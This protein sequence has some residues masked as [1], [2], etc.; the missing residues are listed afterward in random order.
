MAKAVNT[1]R[2]FTRA[3]SL[4]EDSPLPAALLPVLKVMLKQQHGSDFGTKPVPRGAEPTSQ[5]CFT[6]PS[7]PL[8]Q[9]VG[10]EGGSGMK[11]SAGPGALL[12]ARR[13]HPAPEAPG[14]AGG[15]CAPGRDPQGTGS[16]PQA[17][18]LNETRDK[19]RDRQ[20]HQLLS[21]GY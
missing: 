12:A 13:G 6:Q 17:R 1:W 20:I 19:H 3:Q 9:R 11:G 21:K 5:A 10:A 18:V 16:L 4:P 7:T 15:H 2:L 14:L 8:E